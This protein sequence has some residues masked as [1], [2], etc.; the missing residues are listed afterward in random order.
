MLSEG[1][2]YTEIAQILDEKHSVDA[3]KQNLEQSHK[4]YLKRQSEGA[5]KSATKK[6]RKK[7]PKVGSK[8]HPQQK[9]PVAKKKSTNATD[10]NVARRQIAELF[11]ELQALL[12]RELSTG[13][14]SYMEA[15][16]LKARSQLLFGLHP[17]TCL[18]VFQACHGRG[19]ATY[20]DAI[21]EAIE[22]IGNDRLYESDESLAPTSSELVN[23]L[24]I[25]ATEEGEETTLADRSPNIED[26][27]NA[28]RKEADEERER[29]GGDGFIS[30]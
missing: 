21:F 19:F 3:T 12:D 18:D 29:L 5:R 16:Q 8:G 13:R 22:K 24:C 23:C 4:R 15:H 17:Q 27:Y 1:I 6:R 11:L 25:L 14:F 26:A 10:P 20:Q 7:A 2:G 28:A 30:L 9:S